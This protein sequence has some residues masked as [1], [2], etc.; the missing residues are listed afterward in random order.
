MTAGGTYLG[1]LPGLVAFGLGLG[2][3]FPSMFAAASTDVPERD[4]GIASGLASTALQIGTAAGLAVLVGI[5]TTNL[6]GDA[7]RTAVADGLQDGLYVT[8][9]GVLLAISAALAVP[10]REARSPDPS[11]SRGRA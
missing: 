7:S 11:P 3:V 5:A 8:A 9:A 4:S 2:V 1:A 10:R 6:D